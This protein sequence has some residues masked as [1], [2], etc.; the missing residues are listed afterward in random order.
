M[1]MNL[2]LFGFMGSGKSTIGR[3][4]AKALGL[5]LIDM[6][7]VLQEREKSKIEDIFA[8]K[9]ETYFRDLETNLVNELSQQEGLVISTGGGVVLRQENIQNFSKNGVLVLLNIDAETAFLRTKGS[10]RPLLQSADP[11][12]TIREL[13]EKR[14]PFYN[15]VPNSVETCHRSIQEIVQDIV[16]IYDDGMKKAV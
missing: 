13:L 15:Q 4:V 16:R 6:D 8:T 10:K 9:G 12:S 11:A 2:V 14:K 7:Q 5:T 3:H 1:K